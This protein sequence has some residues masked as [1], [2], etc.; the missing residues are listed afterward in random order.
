MWRQIQLD[1]VLLM[2]QFGNKLSL[3]I[4][5]RFEMSLSF[6]KILR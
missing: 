5:L 3:F 6:G 2:R 1:I 4:L